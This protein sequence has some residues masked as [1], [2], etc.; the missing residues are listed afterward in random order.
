MAPDSQI[1][2]R[3]DLKGTII[4]TGANGSLGFCFVQTLL[5]EYPTYFAILAVRDD[6]DEDPNTTKLRKMV[7]G[8]KSP[9]ASIEAVDLASLSSVRS[10]ADGI[11]QRVSSGDIPPISA[12][13][14]NAFNW[15]L[16]GKQTSIDGYDL[17]F[18]VTHLSHFLLVLKL[19]GSMNKKTGRVV[20]LGSDAHDGN[21][22]NPFRTLGAAIPD[23]MEELVKPGSD[24]PGDEQARGFQRYGNAKLATV[25]FMH[26]LNRKLLQVPIFNI[27]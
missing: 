12:I 18:Q 3:D 23:N 7:S 2:G 9:N 22:L 8:S 21:D 19:L 20:F 14:C 16:V 15:S 6:S 4:I 26:M 10:F 1:T 11:I 13:V 24:K 17:S 5:R 27:L 25:M